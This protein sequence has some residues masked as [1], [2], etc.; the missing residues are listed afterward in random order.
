VTAGE[1]GNKIA[2]HSVLPSVR[3]AVTWRSILHVCFNKSD[4]EAIIKNPF[5]FCAALLAF[6]VLVV[7]CAAPVGTV[8]TQ[9]APIEEATVN[10]TLELLITER[11]ETTIP[12]TGGT[13]VLPQT[14]YFL[15]PDDQ[16]VSQIYRLDRDGKTKT[17]LTFEPVEVTDYD[18]S[19]QD[20]VIAYVTGNQL[21]L[22]DADG[23]NRRVLVDGGSAPDLQGAY[24][25]VFSPD[26]QTLAYA[27]NGLN[28]Y[29][30]ATGASL[31]VIQ[32]Q[33]EDMGN[34]QLLPIETYA[35]ERYSPDGMKLLLALG[36]WEVAPSHAVY[37]PATNDLVRYEEMQDYIYC[38]SFHGGPAWSPDGSSFYGVAS[39]HDYSYKSGEL[40]TVDAAN[41]SVTRAFHSSDGTIYLPKEIY[42]APDG[43]LYFF[44][45]I[46]TIESGFFDAPVLTMV[47]SAPDGVADR[48]VLRAENF[49]LMEEALW[50][51]DASFVIVA[52]SLGRDWDLK[53]GVL[54]LYSTDGRQSPVWLA[55]FGRQMKWGP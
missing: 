11:A 32:D 36:H 47:R 2:G 1:E 21:L 48:T 41:G 46:Y 54:E 26:G 37:N 15:A 44:L 51:P 13:A 14:L 38:C 6:T 50:A 55:K 12:Q 42:L 52:T 18:I 30:V 24:R 10:G 8:A 29:S 28:L 43:R 20:G 17:Q 7:G 4:Q 3:T 19:L 22:A 5:R 45:G 9:P 53:G 49:V 33:M 39:A 40:W 31:L 35:P 25:P 34:G 23:S 16:S 27:R